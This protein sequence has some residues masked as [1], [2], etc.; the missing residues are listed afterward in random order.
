LAILTVVGLI[1]LA[2]GKAL[3]NAASRGLSD[4]ES[5]AAW[6]YIAVLV[7]VLIWGIVVRLTRAKPR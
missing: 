7:G 3:L 2:W 1:I 6:V 4:P 5:Q